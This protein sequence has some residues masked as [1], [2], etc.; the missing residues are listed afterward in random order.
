[1]DMHWHFSA[2][3]PDMAP[4]N[5]ELEKKLKLNYDQIMNS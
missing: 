1:M 5:R 4:Q 3:M 2:I